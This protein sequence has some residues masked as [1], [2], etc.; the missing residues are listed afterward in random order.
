[1]IGAPLAKAQTFLVKRTAAALRRAELTD[2]VLERYLRGMDYR[3]IGKELG[4][5]AASCCR[6]VKRYCKDYPAKRA[7]E[8]RAEENTRL[9]AVLAKWWTKDKAFDSKEVETYLKWSKAF[10]ELN[11]LDVQVTHK[12]EHSGEIKFSEEVKELNA[13]LDSDPRARDLFLALD[14]LGEEGVS[15]GRVEAARDWPA[16]TGPLGPSRN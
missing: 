7:E 4:I 15:N 8:Y 10:R 14:S 13:K 16:V 11:G 5:S 6:Y 12:I 1:M 2:Q 9:R 3:S